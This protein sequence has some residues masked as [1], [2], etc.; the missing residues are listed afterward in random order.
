MSSYRRDARAGGV[1]ASGPAALAALGLV[2]F[3][4][5]LLASVVGN[6]VFAISDLLGPGVLFALAAG[7]YHRPRPEERALMFI[8]L[9]GS[10]AKA[11]RLGEA[12]LP[13]LLDAFIADVSRDIVADGGEIHKYVGDEVIATWRLAPGRNDG[14]IVRA[15]RRGRRPAAAGAPPMSGNSASRRISRRA[16]CGRCRGRRDRP[17]QEGD[18]PHR[19]PDEHGRAHSRGLPRTRLPRSPRRR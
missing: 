14:G 10:T 12:R 3:L 18:R 17:L 7:R 2:D 1:G 16:P 13:R 19:R 9:C 4:F 5:T 15:C 6:L 11:E 8:D